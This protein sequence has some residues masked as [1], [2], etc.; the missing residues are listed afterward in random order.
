MRSKVLYG[1]MG[2]LC[3]AGVAH[4]QSGGVSSRPGA[5]PS[6]GA[7]N[8]ATRAKFEPP[9]NQVY[10]GAGLPEYW[11]A[12]GLRTQ[13]QQYQKVAGKPL[14]IVTWF[15]SAYEKDKGD[16][17]TSWPSQYASNLTRVKNAGAMSL[18]KFSVQDYAYSQ[19]KKIAKTSHIAQGVYDAYF[20]Q[21]ADTIKNFGGPVF[22]SINHEM[23]GTW[24]PFSQDFPGSGVTAADFVGSWKRIVDIFRKRGADNV[25][26]VWS[27]NVP[28]VGSVPF[29]KYYPGDEYVDWVGISFYSGNPM[30]NLK[31]I[32]S[33]F[34]SK[35]PIFVTEWATAP[36]KSQFYQGYPGDAKW[37]D[38]FFK[39]LETNYPRVKAISW[40]QYNKED[41]NYLLQRTP[42]QAQ[43][44]AA[45]VQNPRYVSS[46]DGS[47]PNPAGRIETVPVQVTPTEVVLNEPRSQA[48][49]VERVPR[50]RIR[51]QVVP[52]E[53]V[54]VQR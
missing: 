47:A 50:Q 34:A 31:Q 33:T 51:L 53:R 52:T 43:I 39:A 40:F 19:T 42:E 26:W 4:A 6:A 32:Y 54:A 7:T 14:S 48:P 15:A 8:F 2:L 1:V 13:M 22:I 27:P 25:A 45:S 30:S 5:L 46:A 44:Y 18:I 10:H 24:Y 9:G 37:V 38:S 29:Q 49:P 23:N 21:F 11:T 28:D 20:E 41:G 16:R 36:E 3:G 12:S 35:K 17:L